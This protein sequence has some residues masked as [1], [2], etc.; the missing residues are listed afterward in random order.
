M[1]RKAYNAAYYQQHRKDLLEAQ[2]QYAQ[3]PGVKL[4]NQVKQK[5]YYEKNVVH[6]K[7]TAK[8]RYAVVRQDPVLWQQEL[9]SNF[10][11]RLSRMGI[12]FEQSQQILEEQNNGCAIC[13][14]PF[15]KT[16]HIDH[17]HETGMFRGLLCRPCNTGIGFLGDD[18]EILKRAVAYLQVRGNYARSN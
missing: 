17:N 8:R 4:R 13:L 6:R 7:Q 3:R 16:P 2:K 11:R 10:R 1:D 9:K 15:L 5:G 12:S 18:P 14:R